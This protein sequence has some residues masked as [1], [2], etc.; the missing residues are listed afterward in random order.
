MIKKVAAFALALV[1]VAAMWTIPSSA[2]TFSDSLFFNADFNTGKLD[3]TVGSAKGKEWYFDSTFENEDGTKGS[4]TSSETPVRAEFKDAEDIGRKVLSFHKESAV[5]YTD[6]DYTKIIAN[7]TLVAYVKLPKQDPVAGWGYIAGSYWNAN[8]DAGIGIT[9]GMHSIAG[10]GANRK[11]NVI[12][13]DTAKSYTTFTGSRASGEWMQLVYTH[14]G[15]N[16]CY[17][18][19]GVLVGSQPVQ[20]ENI[21]S[22]TDKPTQAFRIGGYNMVSQFCTE[23]ECAYVRVYSAAASESDVKAL[24]EARNQ[25]AP[26]PSGDS[27]KPTENP[28]NGNDNKP[29]EKP[30]D[31]NSSGK[32]D[33]ASTFDA[34]LISLAAVALSSAVIVKKRKH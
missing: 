13:G 7:F 25:D 29:T 16:E 9:Y 34:G 17:Y 26:V 30:A 19:N 14:D 12:Q 18:E 3:D 4:A 33:N 15:V 8:P 21:P 2:S 22:V 11:F 5:F 23:M 20:Q 6:F 1:M 24:Y 32:T 10:V 27:E 28:S 31:N